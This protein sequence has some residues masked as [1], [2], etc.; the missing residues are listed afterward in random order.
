ME[1]FAI[2]FETANDYRNSAC[3]VGVVRYV[4]GVEKDSVYSLIR[5]AKMYF[6]PEFIGIHGISYGDVRNSSEF[7]E[8]WQTIIEPFI[9]SSENKTTYFIA[10][11]A[12][13]DMGVIRAC[14][15]YF[16]M[17]LPDVNYVCTRM[18]A[19]RAWKD[20]DCY[21]LTYLAE[22]FGIEYDAHNALADSQTCGKIFTMAAEKLECTTEDLFFKS[23]LLKELKN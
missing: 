1:Y 8:V 11:N 4:D 3:S 12:P 6:K 14:C 19:R 23:G 9:K 18:T 15:E 17:P 10:H 2:D 16:G 21:A 13:F 22:Q 7:P 20:F 5:P